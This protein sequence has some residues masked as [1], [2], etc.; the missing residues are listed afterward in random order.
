MIRT[1][2][3]R[4][5]NR[6]DHAEGRLSYTFHPEF[7]AIVQ[8]EGQS[9]R[10]IPISGEERDAISQA[11]ID[12]QAVT[13]VGRDSDTNLMIEYPNSNVMLSTRRDVGSRPISDIHGRITERPNSDIIAEDR[14]SDTGPLEFTGFYGG[15]G[16]S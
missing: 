10:S 11:N 14:A 16:T 5:M 3:R 13:S 8:N 15:S 2:A 1:S 7:L 6:V 9:I 4:E 12:F